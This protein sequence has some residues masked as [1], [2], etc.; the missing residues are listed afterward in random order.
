MIGNATNSIEA[1]QQPPRHCQFRQVKD[2]IVKPTIL[3]Q[4]YEPS[5][6]RF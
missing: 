3:R 2:K 5:S 4:V 1:A 6:I